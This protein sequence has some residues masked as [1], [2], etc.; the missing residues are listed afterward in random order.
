MDVIFPLI[1]LMAGT[2]GTKSQVALLRASWE[3]VV[4]SGQPAAVV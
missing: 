4:S 1:T 3:E 2:Q